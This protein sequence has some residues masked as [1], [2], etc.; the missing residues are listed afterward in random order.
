MITKD[1]FSSLKRYDFISYLQGIFTIDLTIISVLI[2]FLIFITLKSLFSFIAMNYIGGVVAQ[3]SLDMRRSFING[4][5]R[6][7]WPSI[8]DKDSG[9]FLNAINFEVPKAASV[10]RISCSILASIF[11][12]I[13]LFIVLF[14][15][16]TEA[17]FG[18]IALGIV[19]I[20]FLRFFIELASEQSKLQVN[21][22]NSMISKIHDVLSGIKVIK[23]MNLSNLISPLILSKATAIKIAIKKQIVAKHGLTYFREPI[24]VAFLCLGIYFSVEEQLFRP[25]ILLA[26]LALFMRLASSIGALQSHHQAFLINFHYL[27]SFQRKLD[28]FQSNKEFDIDEVKGL[29]L[30]NNIKYNNVSFSHN[31][32]T[33]L[34]DASF[35]LPASGLISIEGE[36]GVGKTTLVDML[37]KFYEPASG[38]IYFDNNNLKDMSSRLVRDQIGYVQQEPFIFNDSVYENVR[39]GDDRISRKDVIDALKAA[40]AYHFVNKMKGGID[41]Y[42]GE[43]GSKISGGQKQRIS[44]ARALARK[45]KILILDEATSALDKKTMLDI[46][47]IIKKVSKSSLVIAITHQHEVQDY[48]DCIYALKGQKLELLP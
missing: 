24:V 42:L 44:I 34:K 45:P 48:S 20:V 3:L 39:L 47:K 38:S 26:S 10:Y 5:L 35:K 23:A 13:L 37:L 29:K 46:L 18:G 1:E 25:E 15:F 12:I 41:T 21:I 4:L 43:S 9:E 30:Q 17:A 2:L 22:M 19:L 8:V 6:S 7:N 28:D 11:E 36:S 33:I 27:K 32:K 16:S 40:H 31:D 14:T